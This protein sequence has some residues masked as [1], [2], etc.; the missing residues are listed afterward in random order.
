MSKKKLEPAEVALAAL[1]TALSAPNEFT[2]PL[3][4]VARVDA[5]EALLKLA[6][7]GEKDAALVAFDWLLKAVENQVPSL[8]IPQRIR[9][10]AIILRYK[11]GTL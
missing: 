9:A 11:R 1:V 4:E 7:P 2:N 3:V 6:T 5:A 8:P 10:A